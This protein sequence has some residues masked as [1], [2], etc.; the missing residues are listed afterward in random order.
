VRIEAEPGT[1]LRDVWAILTPEEAYDLLTAL[2]LWAEQD[3]P[4][5]DWHTHITDEGRELTIAIGAAPTR[6]D[7]ANPS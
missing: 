4:D 3:P 6:G 1:D 2:Q 5:P 7:I